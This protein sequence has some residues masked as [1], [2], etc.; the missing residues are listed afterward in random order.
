MPGA[1]GYSIFCWHTILQAV[2]QKV[3]SSHCTN[4]GFSTA[5]SAQINALAARRKLITGRFA[6]SPMCGIL[7]LNPAQ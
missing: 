7:P 1:P 2:P 3:N 5:N 4:M 6:Y